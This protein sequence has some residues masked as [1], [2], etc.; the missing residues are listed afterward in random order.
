[1]CESVPYEKQTVFEA[2]ADNIEGSVRSCSRS[3]ICSVRGCS[4]PFLNSVQKLQAAEVY[5]PS[6]RET[7]HNKNRRV[8]LFL[9]FYKN[10]CVSI[11][12][13]SSKSTMVTVKF[14]SMQYMTSVDCAPQIQSI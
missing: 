13:L 1:M 5:H 9:F 14:Y 11:T 10:H 3:F 7:L 6:A 4:G 12:S 8:I 2:V